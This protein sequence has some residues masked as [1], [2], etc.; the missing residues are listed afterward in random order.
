MSNITKL[1]KPFSDGSVLLLRMRFFSPPKLCQ[2]QILICATKLGILR[3]KIVCKA[4]MT[5]KP[6]SNQQLGLLL[7]EAYLITDSQLEMA[8]KIQQ[9]Q[10]E[11]K[12]ADIFVKNRWINQKTADFFT[13]QWLDLQQNQ[14]S[15]PRLSLGYYLKEAG[16]LDEVQI[17]EIVSEQHQGR[18]WMR[19]GASAV[20][21]GWI[22]QRTIDFF[23]EQLFPEYAM[24]SPFIKAESSSS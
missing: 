13:Y 2:K 1:S 6:L 24:D 10:K 19:L 15:E 22:H 12:L 5:M 3:G 7:K 18:L 9:E 20:L 16:L 23:I 14:A 11:K 8:K 21:K 17:Q 4:P